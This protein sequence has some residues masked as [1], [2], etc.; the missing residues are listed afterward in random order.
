MGYGIRY[1]LFQA[2]AFQCLINSVAACLWCWVYLLTQILNEWV[3]DIISFI[4]LPVW[5]SYTC[6]IQSGGTLW[7]SWAYAHSGMHSPSLRKDCTKVTLQSNDI[8]SKTRFY[9]AMISLGIICNKLLQ[10][11]CIV[12]FFFLNIRKYTYRLSWCSLVLLVGPILL[13]III[14]NEGFIK[15]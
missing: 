12:F 14:G 3:L 7:I 2:M 11:L 6:S 4:C 5:N 10:W 8:Y 15:W 1:L 13:F 9:R